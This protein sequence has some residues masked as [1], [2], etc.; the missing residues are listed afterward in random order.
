MYKLSGTE[1]GGL[2]DLRGAV[3]HAP[4]PLRTFLSETFLND[5]LS[6]YGMDDAYLGLAIEDYHVI[7]G[8][9]VLLERFCSNADSDLVQFLTERKAVQ[10]AS[11]EGRAGDVGLDHALDGIGAMLFKGFLFGVCMSYRHRGQSALHRRRF[12][13]GH[14]KDR[15]QAYLGSSK[16][17]AG[18]E[19][20]SKDKRVST[21]IE[22]G[23][24]LYAGELPE[25]VAGSWV[26]YQFVTAL[27]GA[28]YDGFAI[29]W[30]AG[31]EECEDKP[32][33]M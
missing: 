7:T 1:Q 23:C 6:C 26:Q 33:L 21:I 4:D 31:M 2:R 13:G 9:D 11:L 3:E 30:Y 14:A 8:D 12:F 22:S 20:W 29:G 24:A 25:G 10:L 5:R 19:Q 27:C 32:V 15:A 18:R 16:D 28:W 17:L